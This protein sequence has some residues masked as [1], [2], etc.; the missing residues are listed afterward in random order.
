MKHFFLMIQSMILFSVIF[1]ITE[2]LFAQTDNNIVARR[3]LDANAQKIGLTKYDLSN[4][5]ISDSYFDNISGAQLVY[6]QQS[7]KEIPIFNQLQVLAFKNEKIVSN[8]GGRLKSVEKLAGNLIGIPSVSA[9]EA[10]KDALRDRKIPFSGEPVVIGSEQNGRFIRFNDMGVSHESITAQLMWVP[11]NDASKLVLAWQ[12]YVVPKISS[13]YWLIRINAIDH[14]TVG[15]ND[16]TVYCNW[17]DPAKKSFCSSEL[18]KQE[19]TEQA[20]V[21]VKGYHFGEDRI[22]DLS[23]SII[24]NATYRVI[25]FPAESPIHTGGAHAL[26][27][28]P[29]SAAPGNATSLKWHNN[30]TADFNIT[31][32]NN[33]FSQED[34]NA[35]NVPGSPAASTTTTDPLNFDFTPNYTVTPTQT[36]PNRN[37]QFAITN[38]FYWNNII[39]DLSYQ[40]GFDEVSGNFQASNQGRGGAGNDY[41]IADAQDGSGTNNANFATPA[42]GSSGRMQMYLWNGNPQKD[43]DLDNG[44]IC[45]EF[46]HGISNRLTGGPA[47]AAC[48]QNA[49]QMGEGWSDYFGLMYTQNW[50]TATLTTGFSS[51]RSVGVYAAG[52]SVN[53]I[54]IR[55]KRYSTN[56]AVNNLTMGTT[57]DAQQHNRGELWC[58]TLWDMTWNIINQVGAINT[59]LYDPN[60]NGGNSIAL[61]LVMTG[62][63][64]QPCSPGFIDGR[65]AILQADQILYNGAHSCAIREA[66]RRRGMG[67]FAS[68]GSSGSVLDQTPDFSLASAKLEMTQSTPEVMEGNEVTYYNKLTAGP[69]AAVTNF[70]LTDTLPENVTYVSGGTYDATNRVVS[71]PVNLVA[72]ET[73]TYSFT[74]K[75]N[76]GSYYPTITLFEDPVVDASIPS[77]WT[78]STTT[79]TSWTGTSAR[80]MSAPN[81]YFSGN[82]DVQSD[83]QLTLSNAI[84]LG[85]NPPP[86][87]FRHWFN[88]ESKYDGGVLEFSTNDGTTWTDAQANIYAGGY[89]DVMDATTLLNGRRAWTGNSGGNFIKTKVNLQP[90]A[91]QSIKFRFRFTS[92]V[93]T[94]IE[95]WYVD[96]ITIKNQASIEMQSSLFNST[97]TRVSLNDTI[98]IITERPSCINATISTQP[99]NVNVCVG[100]DAVISVQSAGTNNSFQWQLSTNGGASFSDIAGAINSTLTINSVNA[101]DNNKR[102]RVVVSNACPSSVTSNAV[103]LS[104]NTP[105]SFISQPVSQTICANENASFSTTASGSSNQYQWQVS[106]DGGSSFT[107]ISGANN[108]TLIINN[109]SASLNNNVYHLVITGCSPISVISDNVTL[110]VNSPVDITTQPS[111]VAACP[112]ENASFAAVA[113]GTNLTYEWQVS[114]DGGIN[115]VSIP[116]QT[117]AQLNLTGVTI[118]QNNNQYRVKVV[119]T[120][121]PRTLNSSP[122]TLTV[123]NSAL[124]LTQPT[125][126]NNV[127]PGSSVT[128]NVSAI[129]TGLTYQWQAST[130][131]GN[132]FSNISGETNTSIT[133]TG[134]TP[135]MNGNQYRVLVSSSCSA[136]ALE[137]NPAA[138]YVFTPASIT[139]QPA[140][141]RV[142]PGTNASFS[143]AASGLGTTYQWQVSTDGGINFT[144]LN[145]ETTTTLSLNAVTLTMNNNRYR[146]IATGTSCG[147][148][149]SSSAL[150]TVVTPATITSQPTDI[151]VCSGKDAIFLTNAIGTDLS[152]Q[153]QHSTDGG[154]TFTDLS[155]A[156]ASAYTAQAVSMSMNSH[157]YKVIVTE[158]TCGSITSNM[159][160][161][162][163]KETPAVSITASPSNVIFVGDN[164]TLS[165]NGTSSGTIAWY[166]NNAIITGQTGNSITVSYN[167]TG[168]YLAM[169][170]GINGCVGISNIIEVRDSVRSASFI[171]PNPSSDNIVYVRM[172][173]NI[174]GSTLRSVKI[175]DGKGAKVFDK[176]FNVTTPNQ[177]VDISIIHLA[178]GIYYL[179]ILDNNG[180]QIKKGKL[181]VH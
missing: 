70:L 128:F 130:D 29:W 103:T 34:R 121:C 106:T 144:N 166:Y 161:L 112:G 43:G 150:L 136:T 109:A 181:L 64:L 126:N 99:Q 48:L 38:L 54:G 10:V 160:T 8:K 52:Q 36:T 14:S 108:T 176:S 93:G 115:F 114:T 27:T 133:L 152:Y 137:S 158:Q 33:V 86:L 80:S 20:S 141:Q 83:Q 146:L 171:Y 49:E 21:T 35:D 76:D 172:D 32:G 118:S 79:T 55:S 61:K 174:T 157:H 148:A 168:N 131:G 73:Q 50:A 5:I 110:T 39:H 116:G 13:D 94:S 165:I 37:Q 6:A 63:K 23:P 107:N 41:V 132:N 101:G 167:Q 96:D 56:F 22:N 119:S 25:P 40:Y 142:C 74:V 87:V 28:N 84:A 88:S 159:V 169:L 12:V 24:E 149:T 16:L 134:I 17:D 175:F 15:V 46:A 11:V 140:A 124:I 145:G 58:A 69:C 97:G 147:S 7:Y 100:S 4:T 44:V 122:A 92:D 156:T 179:E 162:T 95:G 91:N 75:A 104:V 66:F 98:T 151:T 68:Q 173:E 30:G 164:T 154:T 155:G 89:T 78:A 178:S 62:M 129:G 105:A 67:A 2:N 127:C 81:S 77:T 60:G 120:I 53:G 111:S 102:Y 19:Q 143:A 72:G 113:T 51:P 85:N 31:R 177:V 65:D 59:N 26:V 3:L 1:L 71:F 163:V 90:F 123:N 117:N 57:V 170:T 45:H 82:T 125:N 180:K 9:A 139:S 153:W 135:G 138:L 42:D 18:S 47:Q